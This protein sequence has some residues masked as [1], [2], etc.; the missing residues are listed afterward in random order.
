MVMGP[1]HKAFL[2]LVLLA[3]GCVST[4]L[5][6][7][8]PDAQSEV[9]ADA[10]SADASACAPSY[11]TMEYESPEGQ[12]QRWCGA[13]AIQL[14]YLAYGPGQP[15][16]VAFEGA[17]TDSQSSPLIGM[18]RSDG[19]VFA[20]TGPV[21]LN[22]RVRS[23]ERAFS[24]ASDEIADFFNERCAFHVVTA[25]PRD[26]VIEARLAAPCE[27]HNNAEG[28][29]GQPVT[30]DHITLLAV[31]IHGP[32]VYGREILGADAGGPTF[33]CR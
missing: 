3:E 20:R 2:V 19:E 10:S 15:C 23:G 21:I 9:G 30:R 12:S 5:G 24:G 13:V 32:R 16:S 1:M 27:L 25:G 33:Y 18:G 28:T 4:A 6:L 17:Y 31:T 22:V 7:T 8:G 11:I 14:V 29:H 26:S